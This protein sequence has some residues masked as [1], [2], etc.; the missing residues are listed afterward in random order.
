[1][2][3]PVPTSINRLKHAM[4]DGEHAMTIR[5]AAICLLLVGAPLRAQQSIKL[6]PDQI[7]PQGLVKAISRN[8][9]VARTPETLRD[10]A[11]A[12]WDENVEPG[13][14]RF[15]EIT[16]VQLL[17]MIAGAFATNRDWRQTQR[18]LTRAAEV[19]PNDAV[20]SY[21]LGLVDLTLTDVPAAQRALQQTARGP[22]GKPHD[23][24]ARWLEALATATSRDHAIETATKA[25]AE[26]ASELEAEME[27]I[28]E[29]DAADQAAENKDLVKAAARAWAAGDRF[30]EALQSEAQ[31]DAHFVA[32]RLRFQAKQF[33]GALDALVTVITEARASRGDPETIANAV[34]GFGAVMAAVPSAELVAARVPALIDATLGQVPGPLAADARIH[35]ERGDAH[36]S[37]NRQDDASLEYRRAIAVDHRLVVAYNNLAADLAA[38]TDDNP[39]H[40]G[41]RPLGKI[42]LEAAVI[43]QP[44]YQ[45][46][47]QSLRVLYGDRPAAPRTSANADALKHYEQGETLFGEGRFRDA[48]AEYERAYTIDPTFAKAYLYHGD[49]FFR[50][51]EYARAVPSYEQAVRL[52]PDDDQARRFL[53]DAYRGMGSNH[54]EIAEPVPTGDLVRIAD[55]ARRAASR[56]TAPHRQF[57]LGWV[58]LARR[59]DVPARNAFRKALEAGGRDPEFV[60]LC[61]RALARTYRVDRSDVFGPV[62]RLSLEDEAF[63]RA[64]AQDA[65]K[66]V[67]DYG[68]A[69]EHSTVS[70]V[71]RTDFDALAELSAR[72]NALPLAASGSA[73][74]ELERARAELARGAFGDAMSTLI[75]FVRGPARTHDG[76]VLAGRASVRL[77]QYETARR[78]FLEARLLQPGAANV[79]EWLALTDILFGAL[80]KGLEE[81]RAARASGSTIVTA[82]MLDRF[83]ERSRVTAPS[84]ASPGATATPLLS[85]AA[86]Q[87]DQ[88]SVPPAPPSVK[89]ENI[90]ALMLEGQQLEAAGNRADALFGYNRAWGA[91]ESIG[92]R[93][94]MARAGEA[95]QR[96][97][98]AGVIEVSAADILRQTPWLRELV[99]AP[100][101]EAK[102]AVLDA[103]RPEDR[104][105]LAH[106]LG[107]GVYFY[108]KERN[109]AEAIIYVDLMLA[110][111]ARIPA[112]P[113]PAGESVKAYFLA[114]AENQMGDI[115][116]DMGEYT[117]ARTHVEAA[118][119]LFT[120]ADETRKRLNLAISQFS[121]LFE[122]GQDTRLNVYRRLGALSRELGDRAA[123]TTYDLKALELSERGDGGDDVDYHLAMG[124]FFDRLDDKDAAFRH[125]R[126]ALDAINRKDSIRQGIE[127]SGALSRIAMV[128]SQLGMYRSAIDLL[129]EG[130][131]IDSKADQNFQVAG[132]GR[133]PVTL[134]HDYH[135]LGNV[136]EAMG[137]RV[138]ARQRYLEAM[139]YALL[140]GS[141]SPQQPIRP[142][143]AVSVSDTWPVLR[144]LAELE[145]VD[146]QG[147]PSAARRDRLVAGLGFYKQA[148]DLIEGTRRRQTGV[149]LVDREQ[150]RLGY[151]RG[152]AGL[153]RDAVDIEAE[154]DQLEPGAGHPREALR[155]AERSKSQVLSEL[156][157]ERGVTARR[158]GTASD[159]V[160][161]QLQRED[162]VVVEYFTSSTRVYVWAFGGRDGR[163]TFATLGDP[164]APLT[165]AQLERE[166]RGY[167]QLLSS[168]STEFARIQERGRELSGLLFPESIRAVIE[169]RAVIVVPHGVLHLL[170]FAALYS[171]REPHGRAGL[172]YVPSM[173]LLGRMLARSATPPRD[174]SLLAI[175][176]PARDPTLESG[177]QQAELPAFFRPPPS[178]FHT[179]GDAS[180]PI[181]E[182]LLDAAA[183]YDYLH[184]FTHGTF[185]PERPLDSSLDFGGTALTATDL[186]RASAERPP[187]THTRLVTLTACETGRGDVQVGDE[188]LGLPRAFLYGGAE[189]MV[190]TLWRTDASFSDR[191]VTRL[192]EQLRAGVPRARAL[193]TAVA[194]TVALRPEYRHPFYW[195]SFVLIGDP[196]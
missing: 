189:A 132:R 118:L 20:A 33:E 182:Q 111:A 196:R 122:Q 192:Y 67:E 93:E 133:P 64:L 79:E 32:A 163:L 18:V 185:N 139:R 175:I 168:R 59:L 57:E 149:A 97:R 169:G 126:V 89:P 26:L 193:A 27:G 17:N 43:L 123:A 39:A 15:S 131:R 82:A 12:L 109:Y 22:D 16:D 8:Y 96:I 115:L 158:P 194:D 53:L 28:R 92:D 124:D 34:A 190:T 2:R 31:I 5:I 90:D 195:A 161:A 6:S 71:A 21:R 11:N 148:I 121:M 84:D 152:K 35:L 48:A 38:F 172:S 154:L 78:F 120:E 72:L 165:N 138:T 106:L 44:S 65:R 180:T 24:A 145:V 141:Y 188:V 105:N 151:T 7:S 108:G 184:I 13:K 68:F 103:F 56:D 55:E 183:A 127:K 128:S 155:Y 178:R 144:S 186:Y 80:D 47:R 98:D 50:V 159:D 49:A 73:P 174:P 91:A 146:A 54:V 63:R 83:V 173:D 94:R 46:A 87:A 37:T 4:E 60:L 86:N 107:L 153:Y 3:G 19:S 88:P 119:R 9:V 142:E 156:I 74:P 117:R 179:P 166:V 171:D 62:A 14:F 101:R 113:P 70:T 157:D 176:N 23:L 69:L 164:A 58:Y 1:V 143:D 99:D 114:Q 100:T 25:A 167:L 136:Y 104:R 52:T 181:P 77:E 137:D 42:L 112:D 191:L 66:T 95:A 41:Y 130:V 160:M 40:A 187:L 177:R 81:L 29:S 61:L 150:A 135:N 45:P 134:L 147:A 75:Q 129:L 125:Y 30:G 162:R 102:F 10:L 51:Q 85:A 110:N 170:P 76:Y 140:S 36:G 116:A